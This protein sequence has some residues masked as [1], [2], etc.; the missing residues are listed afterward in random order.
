MSENARYLQP[1][2]AGATL[3]VLGWQRH[4]VWPV[5][6]NLRRAHAAM[7]GGSRAV[8]LVRGASRRR[9]RSALFPTDFSG[10]SMALLRLAVRLLPPLRVTLLHA[11]R[12]CGDGYLQAAG[13][14]ARTVDA[15]LHGAEHRARARG[16]RFARQVRPCD[17]RLLLLAL[18]Q[19]WAGAVAHC[20]A[21]CEAELLVL[22]GGAGPLWR[23]WRQCLRIAALASRTGCDLL[24]LPALAD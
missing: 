16:N 18:R 8:L 9:Y 7:Q 12:V 21:A 14:A 20:A 15:C 3:L 2:V 24:L 17:T 6:H 22:A 1:G 5:L 10:A 4:P 11:Y 19:S 23:Q 13:V